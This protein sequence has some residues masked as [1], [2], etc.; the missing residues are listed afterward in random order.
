MDDFDISGLNPF[1]SDAQAIGYD[2]IVG[3]DD[4]DDDD[5]ADF[6][7]IEGDEVG[8][9]RR[10]GRRGLARLKALRRKVSRGVQSVNMQPIKARYLLFGGTASTTV[11]GALDVKVTVQEPIKPTRLV[12]TAIDIS[13]PA[14]PVVIAPVLYNIL[15]ILVGTKSQLSS[16]GAIN[17][18]MFTSDSNM[19]YAG[20]DWDTVQSGTD[21]TVRI[22]NAP[23]DSQFNVS[24]AGIA[25]R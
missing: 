10:R 16:L 25:Q 22:Q 5:V 19:L 6:L 11:A 21:F 9:R 13:T 17:G 1:D 24:V 18:S 3:Y 7:G 8:A 4:D 2:D 12:V 20:Y 23:A 15:D 14:T